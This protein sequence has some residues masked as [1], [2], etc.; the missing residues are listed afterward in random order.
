MRRVLVPLDDSPM[1]DRALKQA[2]EDYPDAELHLLHVIDYVEAGYA[3]SPDMGMGA[4]IDEWEEAARNRAEARFDEA[5]ETARAEEFDGDV[6][7][8]IE[9]GPPS[10]TIVDYAE[11][12]DMDYVVMGSHGRSG[13]SRV[14]LGSVAE[15][16][17]RRA[18]CPVLVVR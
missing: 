1:A 6:E 3:A 11:E 15:S 8:A 2:L 4:Y 16:V 10:R 13:V 12:H 7:T 5:R 9:V 17:V 18:P 14:L